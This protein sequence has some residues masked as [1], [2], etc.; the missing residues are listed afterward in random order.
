MKAKLD[1]ETD[2]KAAQE[3]ARDS[4]LQT[5]ARVEAPLVTRWLPLIHS[6]GS[7][8]CSAYVHHDDGSIML[9]KCF[10]NSYRAMRKVHAP[11]LRA[12][13]I[14]FLISIHWISNQKP[15]PRTCR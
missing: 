9:L 6:Y 13:K 11:P 12:A 5:S 15:T 3:R 1:Y 7:D 10:L 14:A 2:S 4:R 8:H